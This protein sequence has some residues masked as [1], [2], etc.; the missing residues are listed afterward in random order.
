MKRI[1][2]A[3]E[4]HTWTPPLHKPHNSNHS[5]IRHSP[6]TLKHFWTSDGIRVQHNPWC[7]LLEPSSLALIWSQGTNINPCWGQGCQKATQTSETQQFHDGLVACTRAKPR[8]QP[9]KR[10]NHPSFETGPR[11]Q[12]DPKRELL[13]LKIEPQLAVPSPTRPCLQQ[14]VQEHLRHLFRGLHASGHCYY[15]DTVHR[16][17]RTEECEDG[18][19]EGGRESERWSR[20]RYLDIQVHSFVDV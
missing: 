15:E 19:R 1:P 4:L 11:P 7:L 12:P 3:L 2:R 5:Q 16:A 10:K 13:H 17:W 9:P 6:L 8:L 18:G 14:W 20:Y